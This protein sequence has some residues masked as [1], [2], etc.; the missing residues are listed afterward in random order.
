MNSIRLIPLIACKIHYRS[1]NYK[2][3]TKV[4]IIITLFNEKKQHSNKK[5]L[6][7]GCYFK[8]TYEIFFHYVYI[9]K[10]ILY[11]SSSK[12]SDKDIKLICA[13]YEIV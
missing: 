10:I 6:W 11:V 2:N 7:R 12:A 9:L 1:I 5:F 8:Y 4:W 13:V 3:I